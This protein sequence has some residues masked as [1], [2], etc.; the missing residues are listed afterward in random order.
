M[1]PGNERPGS[2]GGT[3][4][5]P[6]L[7]P[8]TEYKFEL[9]NPAWLKDRAYGTMS[10][11][12]KGFPWGDYA[13][14]LQVAIRERWLERYPLAAR[15]GMAG[16][17]CQRFVIARDGTVT[18]ID[19]LRPSKHPSLTRAATDAINAASRLPPLPEEFPGD[20]EGVTGCF[21]YNMYPEEAE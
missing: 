16:Y 17:T 7:K 10:F 1:S 21:W 19:I 20:S 4:A 5:T 14:K 12:T 13:R 6:N 18:S 9:N 11:D 3:A 8:G 2:G 15:Q